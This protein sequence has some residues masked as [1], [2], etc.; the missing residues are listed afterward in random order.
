MS[1]WFRDESP[2]TYYWA[3]EPRG[4]DFTK[5]EILKENGVPGR[6]LDKAKGLQKPFNPNSKADEHAGKK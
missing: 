5:A 6:G 3:L 2:D 4:R 1:N